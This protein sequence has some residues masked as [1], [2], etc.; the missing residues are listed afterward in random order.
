[1]RKSPCDPGAGPWHGYKLT[2]LSQVGLVLL[3]NVNNFTDRRL[4]DKATLQS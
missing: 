1:M 3:W 4:S 2:W